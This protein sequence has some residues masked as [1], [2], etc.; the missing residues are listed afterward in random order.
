M[1][2]DMDKAIEIVFNEYNYKYLAGIEETSFN[3]LFSFLGSNGEELTEPP[4]AVDKESGKTSV[5]FPPHHIEEWL[6]RKQLEIP[7]QYR[8]PGEIKY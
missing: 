5:F 3:F 2:I 8:F 6:S 1:M 7:E 4:T